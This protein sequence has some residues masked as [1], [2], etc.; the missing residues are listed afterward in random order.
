MKKILDNI[1]NNPTILLITILSFFFNFFKLSYL[2]PFIGDQGWF[3]LSARDMLL[4]GKIPLVGITSSHTWLHQ[5]PLWTYVLA[6]LFKVSDFNPLFPGYVTAGVGV[7]TVFLMYFIGKVVFSK[8]VGLL[9]AFL[10]SMSPL[11]ILEARMPYHT[12]FIPLITLLYFYSLFKWIT[13]NR[14]GFIAGFF[15]LAVLYNLELATVVLAGPLLL[16]VGIGVYKKTFWFKN[17]LN[18]RTLLPALACFFLPLLPVILYDTH[19]GYPQTI[20]FAVWLVYAVLHPILRYIMPLSP[21]VPGSNFWQITLLYVREVFFLSSTITAVTIAAFGMMVFFYAVIKQQLY[22][23]KSIALVIAFFLV[24]VLSYLSMMTPSE[25]YLPMAIPFLMFAFAIGVV[26][27]AS[28]KLRVLLYFG[29]CLLA[30]VNSFFL[31]QKHYEVSPGPTFAERVGVVKQIIV[32]AH[33]KP[34]NLYA[35]G[36]GSQFQSF[37]M[38]YQYLAWWLGDPPSSAKQKQGFFIQEKNGT[39]ILQKKV[40]SSSLRK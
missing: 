8:N 15:L 22:K 30:A 28:K 16:L 7:L 33:G 40:V 4:T 35:K 21:S 20:M 17:I 12:S 18:K 32:E 25:A 34:Y 11:V 10:Y 1:R 27:I 36:A 19:H 6:L 37:T 24:T 38:N 39:I 3:Y 13:G 23:Q 26:S 5:G 31:L 29:I 9:A 14:L 2:M